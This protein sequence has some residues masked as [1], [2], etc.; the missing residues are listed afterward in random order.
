[1]GTGYHLAYAAVARGKCV[2]AEHVSR[3]APEEIPRAAR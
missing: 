2:V 1:M 3:D